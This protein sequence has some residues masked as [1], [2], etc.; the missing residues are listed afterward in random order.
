MRQWS[1]G[2][3]SL[4]RSQGDSGQLAGDSG[5]WIVLK[6]AV[7]IQL[8]GLNLTVVSWAILV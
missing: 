3:W 1:V 8:A 4:G 7:V 6:T 2:R 5:Q